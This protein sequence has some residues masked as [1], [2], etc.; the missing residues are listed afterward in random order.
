MDFYAEG[1]TVVRRPQQSL[2]FFPDPQGQG[3]LRP[4]GRRGSGGGSEGVLVRA[5]I[6]SLRARNFSWLWLKN[7]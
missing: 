7:R 1:L 2:Y 3:S 4:T 5:K 6:R